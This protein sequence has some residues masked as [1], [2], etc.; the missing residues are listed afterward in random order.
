MATVTSPPEQRMILHDVR[1]A[2]YEQLLENYQDSSSPRFTY[3]RGAL[4]IMSPSAE[5]VWFNNLPT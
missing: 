3:D 5:H 1:W 4:E 2:L